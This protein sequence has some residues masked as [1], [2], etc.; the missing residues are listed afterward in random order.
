M[1]KLPEP[2]ALYGIVVLEMPIGGPT[3]EGGYWNVESATAVTCYS[4]LTCISGTI[5]GGYPRY[6][7]PLRAYEVMWCCLRPSAYDARAM[8]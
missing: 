5:P 7:D 1:Q 3:G 8:E 6:S 4:A 2:A